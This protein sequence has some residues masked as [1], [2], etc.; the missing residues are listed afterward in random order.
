MRYRL[1]DSIRRSMLQT[2]VAT[3][4]L[5]IRLSSAGRAHPDASASECYQT[6]ILALVM[7]KLPSEKPCHDQG[8]S[9]G[10][11]QIDR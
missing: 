3:P 10:A 5:S 11:N 6:V 4:R 1:P 7:I 8:P 9:C 2:A